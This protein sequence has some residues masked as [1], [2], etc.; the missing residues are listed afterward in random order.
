MMCAGCNR[1]NAE[2]GAI[3]YR[4]LEETVQWIALGDR[5]RERL[6]CF[7]EARGETRPS[8]RAAGDKIKSDTINPPGRPAGIAK[9]TP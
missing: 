8:G 4:C 3:C 7:R 9:V 1:R 5:E 6:D 2:V